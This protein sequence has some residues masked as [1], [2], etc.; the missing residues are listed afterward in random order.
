[1]KHLFV[2]FRLITAV[3]WVFSNGPG[4]HSDV[5]PPHKWK[6]SVSCGQRLEFFRPQAALWWI[7]RGWCVAVLSECVICI[8]WCSRHLIWRFTGIIKKIRL[9]YC[10][11]TLYLNV[12]WILFHLSCSVVAILGF[13]K[14]V[15]KSMLS[16]D[17]QALMYY[18]CHNIF[19]RFIKHGW[20]PGR[21]SV[22]IMQDRSAPL[23]LKAQVWS[24]IC[25]TRYDGYI[26]CSHS[27]THQAFN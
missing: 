11:L 26:T 23:I 7:Q 5:E 17:W 22:W 27:F 13:Y 3:E 20:L 21:H 14:Y 10:L 15:L 16:C 25:F 18:K 9:H 6:L 2:C 19:S 8:R 12:L 1:M 24:S 4:D